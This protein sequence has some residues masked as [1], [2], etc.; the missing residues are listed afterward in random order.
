MVDVLDGL[1][2]PFP[3]SLDILVLRQC[4]AVERCHSHSEKLVEIIRVDAK[5][6]HSLQNKH[7]F[8]FNILQYTKV[9]INTT[10]VALY[11]SSLQFFFF[12]HFSIINRFIIILAQNYLIYTTNLLHS[13]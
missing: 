7:F 12:F 6:R 9:E 8:F 10:K 4:Q 13:H 5:E 1:L 2:S 11:K 3:V